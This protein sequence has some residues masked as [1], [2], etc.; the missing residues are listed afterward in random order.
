[1]IE[2]LIIHPANFLISLF[3]VRNVNIKGVQILHDELSASHEAKAWFYFISI[4][5]AYLI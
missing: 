5:T 4:F 1:M 2:K 3:G